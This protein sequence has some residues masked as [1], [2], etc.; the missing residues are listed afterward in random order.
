MYILWLCHVFVSADAQQKSALCLDAT[1]QWS[2]LD[3]ALSLNGRSGQAA[4]LIATQV[5]DL[6]ASVTNLMLTE[7]IKKII[8]C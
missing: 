2:V 4:Q 1:A 5:C 7:I 8:K 3:P 6:Y